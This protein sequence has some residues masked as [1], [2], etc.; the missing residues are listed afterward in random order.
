MSATLI[1][2]EDFNTAKQQQQQAAQFVRRPVSVLVHWS[3]SGAWGK[4][5]LC[6]FADF[7]ARAQ[8]VALGY[9]G[10]GYQKTSV[11]V[12][13][14]D[15][16]RYQARLDLAASDTHGFTDH[17]LA[18][19]SFAETEKGRAY[20]QADGWQSLLD[21]V[22]GIDFGPDAAANVAATRA[23]GEAAEKAE[24]DRIEA[25]KQAAMDARHQAR[26]EAERLADEW[27]AAL[28]IPTDAKAVIV[29][30]LV[31]RNED[32]SDPYADYYELKDDKVIILA[33]SKHTRDLFSE[34]RKAAKNHPETAFLSD[35][36]DSQ[37]NRE[38]YSMGKGFYL[39][40][41]GF[42]RTG[43]IIEKVR[44]WSDSNRG[45]W[46]PCG[47]IA[48]PGYQGLAASTVA[49]IEQ[50]A[51]SVEVVLV[52]EQAQIKPKFSAKQAGGSW[53]VTIQ[54][55]EQ[56]AEFDGIPATSMAD[57][58]RIAWAM[59]TR[60]TPP[61]DDP[62]GSPLPGEPAAEQG[63]AVEQGATAPAITRA[64]LLGDYRGRV[65]HKRE[66]LKGL[67]GKAASQSA[68]RHVAVRSILSLISPGQPILV[69][70][71][72]EKR[73]R[74]DLK[75]M[76][77]HMEKAVGL[78]NKANYLEEKA[79]SVG[80]GGIA[81]DN[82][83]AL[84]LLQAKLVRR[85]ARQQAM[86]EANKAT[87]GTYQGWQLSNNAAEIRRLRQRIDLLETLHNTAPLDQ[88][89]AGWRMFEDD[90]RIQIHFDDKP[91]PELRKLCK[92]AGFVWSS[93]RCAWVRKVTVRAVNEA[94]RLARAL[95]AAD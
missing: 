35:P 92:G 54:Q 63:E 59:L 87:R 64:Q 2:M 41:R 15:G 61:D 73:H 55:G 58:C 68:G 46:I 47:E 62:S 32:R 86:K 13:F 26:I 33:W 40:D 28:V 43:W 78:A 70:H 17:C 10:G 83:D 76:D 29:A 30:R 89:G 77:Q 9:V 23:A 60:P 69:G 74:R 81:S 14:D 94:C 36:A 25:E 67:A 8:V 52:E 72:S 16:D 65:E 79:A 4:E 75:R 34:M 84:A 12:N 93:S 18:M 57:A 38:K 88:A 24:Q 39:T 50:A 91:A 3:E 82:P 27:R 71:H 42:I 31:S 95:P 6:T 80:H 53:S 22:R 44:L 56:V 66:R 51:A 21:F 90:G 19:L 48:I 49:P 7:E 1:S 85:E 37:E 11:T 5:E 45:K 20:Y